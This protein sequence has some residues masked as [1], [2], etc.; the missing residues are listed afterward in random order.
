MNFQTRYTMKSKGISPHKLDIPN[1]ELLAIQI[2]EGSLTGLH[3]SPFHGYSAE[4][5]EHKMYAPGESVKFIDWKVYAKTEKLYIKKFDEETN[6][7]VR[8][9]IDAS[10][11]MYYP[12]TETFDLDRLNK[13]GFSVVA[14]AVLTEILRRQ[15]DAVGLSVYCKELMISLPEK[16]NTLHRK[17]VLGT[18]EKLLSQ[19]GRGRETDP[20]KNLHFIAENLKRRSLSVLFSDLW[21]N[22][23]NPAPLIDALKHLRYKSSELIVFHVLNKKAEADFIF[24]DRPTRF[25]DAET[26]DELNIYPGEIKRGYIRQFQRY[27]E[28][29]REAFYK[30]NIDYYPVHTETP[31][32]DII[33]SYLQKRLRMK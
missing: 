4:F 17:T 27:I 10:S 15:R 11:S 1:L 30:Y 14:S 13:I 25:V 20:V 7:R 19:P 8:L 31:Y 5:R 28:Q 26:G 22:D 21:M 3:R 32:R 18:L 24:P 12:E 29:I 16:T 33:A 2:V 6:M 9:I 23:N